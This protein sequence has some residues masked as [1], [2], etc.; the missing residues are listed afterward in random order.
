VLYILFTVLRVSQEMDQSF[1]PTITYHL[2]FPAAVA[3][4]VVSLSNAHRTIFV[5]MQMS[6]RLLSVKYEPN[7]ITVANPVIVTYFPVTCYLFFF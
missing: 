2:P 5:I 4:Y 6:P 3:K 7:F 1:V